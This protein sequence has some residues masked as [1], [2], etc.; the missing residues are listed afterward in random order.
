MGGKLDSLHFLPP[1]LDERDA[2]L[3]TFVQ[4]VLQYVG[5][6]LMILIAFAAVTDTNYYHEE[7]VSGTIFS[8][9]LADYRL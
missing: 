4:C 2:P 1:L 9:N 3:L 6:G 7:N 8:H 5:L